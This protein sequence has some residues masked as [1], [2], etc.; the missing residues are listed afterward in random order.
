MNRRQKKKRD[1]FHELRKRCCSDASYTEIR[2]IDRQYHELMVEL[3][4]HKRRTEKVRKEPAS[5][6]GKGIPGFLKK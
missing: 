4:R 1:K 3:R 2:Q 5:V 6:R